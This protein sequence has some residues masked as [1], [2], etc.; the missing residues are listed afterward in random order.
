LSVSSPAGGGN[1][2]D[3]HIV[4]PRT[5]TSVALRRMVAVT[6]PGARLADAWST[7]I[8]VVGERPAALGEEWLT[9][10]A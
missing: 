2:T 7:A 5:G 6:G 9:Y 10:F 4:D 3:G 1:A 8:V